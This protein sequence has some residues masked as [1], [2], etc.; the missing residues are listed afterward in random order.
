RPHLLF[1]DLDRLCRISA[2]RRPLQ[3][4]YAGKAHPRDE[5]GKD[6]IQRIFAWGRELPPAVKLAYLPNYDMELGALC[7]AGVDLWLNTPKPPHE[8]SGTSGMKA[9]HNGVPSLSVL[10]GWWL[11]G[12]VEGVTG[13]SIG[14]EKNGA[15]STRG[16]DEDAAELYFKL[17]ERILPLYHGDPLRWAELMRYTIALN[18]S[19]FNTQRMVQ[20]Y[21]IQAYMD[22]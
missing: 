6:L 12:H 15:S 20:E 5:E 2:R 19:M 17:E 8:A 22:R 13:W 9:A 18:A 16:D 3:I 14:F 1:H 10:D 11:E 4:V 7:T 21:V